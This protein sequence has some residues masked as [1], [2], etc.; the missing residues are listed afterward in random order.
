MR[1]RQ[2]KMAT[3]NEQ[4]PPITRELRQGGTR[5]YDSAWSR[6]TSGKRSFA[7][8]HL[9]DRCP[10]FKAASN[11]VYSKGRGRRAVDKDVPVRAGASE[12]E[13]V[14]IK[15]NRM[16][17]YFKLMRMMICNQREMISSVQFLVMFR[18]PR[19]RYYTVNYCNTRTSPKKRANIR[20][21]GRT[22]T[23]TKL[24]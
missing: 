24:V 22:S 6:A 1:T 5:R 23:R 11:T 3:N 21:K 20:K 16:M 19:F 18:S 12:L 10:L 13:R 14:E 2:A 17:Y 9:K 8:P 15:C 4:V 7:V